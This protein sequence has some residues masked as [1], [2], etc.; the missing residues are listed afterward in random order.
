[1]NAI[2]LVIDRLHAGYLGAMG[3]GWID[4]PAIDRLAA[5][6]LVFNQMLLDTPRLDLLYRSY[7]QGWHAMAPPP[8]ENRPS[9]AALLATPAS[10][11]L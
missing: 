9:L 10:T 3:N 7:W 8:P 5:G 1:M 6:S 11:R 2:V 4:T